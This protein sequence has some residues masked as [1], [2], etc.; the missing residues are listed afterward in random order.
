MHLLLS[1]NLRHKIHLLLPSKLGCWGYKRLNVLF[2][3]LSH[4]KS[5]YRY[6]HFL[7]WVRCSGGALLLAGLFLDPYHWQ[8]FQLYLRHQGVLIKGLCLCKAALETA[9]KWLRLIFHLEVN[10]HWDLSLITSVILNHV[11][12][13]NPIL[14]LLLP[15]NLQVWSKLCVQIG[16]RFFDMRMKVFHT[17]LS[18]VFGGKLGIGRPERSCRC[19]RCW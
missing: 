17:P 3:I 18:L 2:F 4:Y 6:W 5:R 10:C 8:L 9:F 19:L 7:L 11:L 15:F 13:Y 16:V 12:I 14:V 1:F